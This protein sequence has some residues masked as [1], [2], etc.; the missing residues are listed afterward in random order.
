MRFVKSDSLY[1]GLTADGTSFSCD[2]SHVVLSQKLCAENGNKGI[3]LIGYGEGQDLYRL[4]PG[5]GASG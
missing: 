2:D 1:L 3:L 5:A 4:L